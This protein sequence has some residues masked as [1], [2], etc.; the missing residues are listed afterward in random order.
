[1]GI[2]RGVK[3]ASKVVFNHAPGGYVSCGKRI[4]CEHCGHAEFNEGSA[5]LNTAGMTFLGLDWANRTA[6]TLMCAACGRIQW[7]GKRPDRIEAAD[8]SFKQRNGR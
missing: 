1:M 7:Y 5:Q 3:R 6:T 2:W 4:C 8:G